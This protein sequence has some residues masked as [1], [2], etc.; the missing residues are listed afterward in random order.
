MLKLTGRSNRTDG[1]FYATRAHINMFGI[2]LSIFV[3]K[4]GF[5]NFRKKKKIPNYSIIEFR[6]YKITIGYSTT[7]V[8]KLCSAA[9]KKKKKMNIFTES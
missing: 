2:K 8:P 3:D 4:N 1:P 9:Y 7:A 6:S 5:K